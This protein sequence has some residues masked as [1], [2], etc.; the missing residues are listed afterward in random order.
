M[1]RHMKDYTVGNLAKERLELKCKFGTL[2][3]WVVRDDDEYKEIEVDLVANDGKEYQVACIGTDEYEFEGNEFASKV[4]TYLWNG[5][6]EEVAKD[7]YMD[8]CG[9]GYYYDPKE[10]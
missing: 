9:E 5:M 6:Q 4:H 1:T 2:I 10:D 7:Y 8:P 3:A